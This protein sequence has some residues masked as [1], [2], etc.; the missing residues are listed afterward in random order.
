VIGGPAATRTLDV[1][2]VLPK[3]AVT[4]RRVGLPFQRAKVRLQA[5]ARDPVSKLEF[6]GAAKA[7]A[8]RLAFSTV[9]HSPCGRALAE[10]LMGALPP[11]TDQPAC[12][13]AHGDPI[14]CRKAFDTVLLERYESARA[15][16]AGEPR[17]EQQ[18]LLAVDKQFRALVDTSA[19][20]AAELDLTFRNRPPAHFAFGA[21]SGVIARASL[22]RPRVKIDRGTIVADPLGRVVTMA[23]VNWS[24][25]GYD[26]E[27]AS[28]SPAERY[29]F[30][31]GAVLTPDFGATA[32]VNVLVVRG[33][34]ITIGG[35]LLF[36][37]GSH[38]HEV[39]QPPDSP[40]DPFRIALG[41][42]LVIGVS[43]TYK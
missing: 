9:P 14:A 6:E 42:G 5:V 15:A 3:I 36:G 17:E 31:A 8:A 2:E 16:C 32:G 25:A 28:I 22:S 12:S 37:K 30:F 24:P 33:V 41:R 18:A 21:G 27:S 4:V 38:P 35:A 7:L 13:S 40:D 1:P 34:G 29:R 39:G 19:A 26:P 10:D 43:Y 20:P 11:V 23:F